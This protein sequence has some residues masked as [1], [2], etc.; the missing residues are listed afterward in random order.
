MTARIAGF[1]RR[2]LIAAAMLLTS[3][4]CSIALAQTVGGAFKG[5]GNNDQPIQIE[6]D[7]LEV[8]DDQNTAL[9]TG[10]VSVTQGSTIFRASRIKVFYLRGD[11]ANQ[12]KSGIR[13]IEASGKVAVSA[14]DNRATADKA[15]IDMVGETV[16]LT[17]NVVMSQGKNVAT[18]C[19]VSVNL[20]TSVSSIKPC[21]S[22]NGKK[23]GR[24]V[25]VF[26]PKSRKQ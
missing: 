4:T 26:D 11:A 3:A 20:R 25:I 2:V 7:N 19:Q 21:G 12:S 17:G 18:G 6:A 13:R 8:I 1:A 15:V 22:A 5:L 14:D 16:L 24:P 10:N 23:T 9:L